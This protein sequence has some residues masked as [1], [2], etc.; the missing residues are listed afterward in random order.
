MTDLKSK[1]NIQIRN[2]KSEVVSNPKIYSLSLINGIP[3]FKHKFYIR[4]LTTESNSA[5]QN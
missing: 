4:N 5:Y 3:I 2:I 1:L